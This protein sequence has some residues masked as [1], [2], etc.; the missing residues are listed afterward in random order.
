MQEKWRREG[1]TVVSGMASGIDSSAHIGALSMGSTCAVLG[2]GVDV[3]YPRENAELY[4]KIL[5][6]GVIISEFL[7][8]TRPDRWRFPVRK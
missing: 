7:P 5:N 2:C 8:G 4:N 6:K 3:V 1:W